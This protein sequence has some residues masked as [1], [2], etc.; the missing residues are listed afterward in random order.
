MDKLLGKGQSD[1]LPEHDNLDKLANDFSAFF[2]NKIETIR[3]NL[4]DLESTAEPLSCPPISELLPPSNVMMEEFEPASEEEILK[5]IKSSSKASCSLDP[6]PTRMLADNFLPELIPIITDIVNA[7][8]KEGIF[9]DDMKTAL[10]RPLLKKLSLDP[11]VK[12]NFRPVSNLSFLSK[13]IEKVVANR[14]FAHMS[15]NGLHD[16]MQSA[17]KPFHSTETALLK[18]QNDILQSLDKKSGVFLAVIDWQ[19]LF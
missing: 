9:P 1:K 3:A 15:S 19:W 5:I 2:K 6:I 7:S 11:E 18:V 16:I 8:L 12:K 4:S 10:V 17:Y 14:L 13:V